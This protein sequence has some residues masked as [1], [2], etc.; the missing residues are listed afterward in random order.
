M[1]YPMSSSPNPRKRPAPGASPIVAVPRVQQQFPTNQPDQF[2]GWAGGTVGVNNMA[3][4]TTRGVPQ[5][6]AAA[7]SGQLGQ[8]A[9][10][11]STALARRGMNRALV[12]TAPRPA[13][14]AN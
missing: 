4:P 8:A 2:L 11:T 7:A 14:D 13:F 10:S 1:W 9:P 6:A 5:Y 12:P 3:D